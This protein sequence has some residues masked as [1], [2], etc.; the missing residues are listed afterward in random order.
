MDIENFV[1]HAATSGYV[2]FDRCVLN[3]LCQLYRVAPLNESELNTWLSNYQYCSAVIEVPK[4]SAAE[5]CKYVLR[6]LG[7]TNA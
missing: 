6:T 2:F 5:R 7:D 1:H 3:A 4:V